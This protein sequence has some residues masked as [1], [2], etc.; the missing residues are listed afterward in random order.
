MLSRAF[1]YYGACDLSHVEELVHV[2]LLVI[3]AC[4][5]GQLVV[6]KDLL[7]ACI[8]GQLVRAARRLSSRPVTKPAFRQRH[9]AKA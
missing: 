4:M 9:H 3:I 2:L 6:I 7:H 8:H 5:R 1:D